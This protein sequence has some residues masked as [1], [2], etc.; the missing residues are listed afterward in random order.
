MATLKTPV[1]KLYMVGG[2]YARR[3]EKLGI[4]TVED[5]LYHLPSRYLDLSLVSLVSRVQPG[6]TVTIRGEMVAIKNQYTKGGKKIQVGTLAD[7]SGQ[8][9]V[10]WFNQP[11]LV[12]TLQTGTRVS[13]SGK[14]D[15]F[16]RRLSLVSPEY[17]IVRAGKPKWE[18]ETIHTG[19]LVP[20]YPETYGVSSKW[21][22]SRLSP[23]VQNLVPQVADWLPDSLR[24][25]HELMSL[26]Q[27]LQLVH[28]P[29]NQDLAQKGR[30]RLAFDELFLMALTAQVRKRDW[31]K[32]HLAHPVRVDQEKVI[33]FISGLPFSLTEAQKKATRMILS[34][35]G[36][37]RPMNRLLQGDVGSGKTVVA[38]VAA[39]VV[40]ANGLQTALMAPT[41]ILANQHYQTLKT[42]LEPMGSQVALLTSSQKKGSGAD[43]MVGTH[44]LIYDRADFDR[45]GLTVIDE[46]HRFGVEQRAKL[47][48]KGS[49]A[50]VTPHVLTMTATPIPRTIALTLYGD[51]DL[52]LIDEMPPGRIKT[53]TWVVPPAKRASAYDWIR[54]Q[55]KVGNQAFIICPLIEE[56]THETLASTRAAVSEYK[57]LKGDI[58]PELSLGLIHGRLKA[59]EK[60]RTLALFRGGQLEI[61][62]ATPVVEVG[63]DIPGATIMMVEGSERFGLA[64]L[65]QL[66]GR[67]GRGAKQSYCLLFSESDSQKTLTRLKALERTN[68]GL[69]LSELDLKLRGPGEI[70][71]AQQHGFPTLIAADIGDLALIET[72]RQA[73]IK[74]ISQ[75]ENLTLYPLLRQKLKEVKMKPVEPN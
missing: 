16:G 28:F 2:T 46:Q 59:E 40:A 73:A 24:E 70:Y 18:E 6:E 5:L 9:E 7:D 20:I 41:E 62:V 45:L 23:L 50:G 63:I 37:K 61:L 25:E 54:K 72:T 68:L 13:L 29:Q 74:I 39:Q 52:S 36:Q 64:Q 11:F 12:K 56:S 75:D 49:Q 67:V 35:L 57:R 31:A 33:A 47:I 19:R 10:V 27:A 30:R 3:L 38:A 17:E 1:D 65:H 8:I 22:R 58:F 42:L 34:D 66:R 21:L 44:A 15:F 14:V 4:K 71:G 53:K 43:V 51:L 55:I 48:H 26:S 69:A 60:E 32:K